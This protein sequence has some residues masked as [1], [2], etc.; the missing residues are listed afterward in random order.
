MF[1]TLLRYLISLKPASIG[2]KT[3]SHLNFSKTLTF[4]LSVR[5]VRDVFHDVIV[6]ICRSRRVF[7]PPAQLIECQLH[8]M[9]GQLRESSLKTI[10]QYV[11]SYILVNALHVY[12][13][14][15]YIL[16]F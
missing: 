13:S 8:L 6:A 4:E 11:S 16:I 10:H 7:L 2:T 15:R 3:V 14:N 9:F 1:F 5:D 12:I